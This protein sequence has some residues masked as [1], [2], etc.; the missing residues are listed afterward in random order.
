MNALA[1]SDL[2][3]SFQ[4]SGAGINAQTIGVPPPDCG[5]KSAPIVGSD[6][7]WA[8][9]AASAAPEGIPSWMLLAAA[10]G[11]AYWYFTRKKRRKP[12]EMFSA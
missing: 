11:A 1:Q 10:A 7:Q 5:P 4:S 3:V 2:S 9:T 6:G 8:C 12:Q